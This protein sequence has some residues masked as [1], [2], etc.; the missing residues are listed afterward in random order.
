[1]VSSRFG[2]RPGPR[3][4]PQ[5][6]F[7]PPPPPPP[8]GYVACLGNDPGSIITA[9]LEFMWFPRTPRKPPFPTENITQVCNINWSY[10]D[11]TFTANI[12]GRYANQLQ[13]AL[14]CRR[15]Q[16]GGNRWEGRMYGSA[17]DPDANRVTT[18]YGW[19]PGPQ[20][21]PATHPR[22]M[23][24][25]WTIPG[26]PGWTTPTWYMSAVQVTWENQSAVSRSRPPNPPIPT[27]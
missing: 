12:T 19:T 17:I 24:V 7:P 26:F 6:C 22:T 9:R 27:L 10:G 23:K 20:T 16:F 1:M 14:R 13:V 4:T 25:I 18:G 11:I 3:P 15:N 8:P 21:L 2:T 5:T